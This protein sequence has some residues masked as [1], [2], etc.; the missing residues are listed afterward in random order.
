MVL[1]NQKNNYLYYLFLVGK[2]KKD[3]ARGA[4][5]ASGKKAEGTA[6]GEMPSTADLVWALLSSCFCGFGVL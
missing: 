6:A 3:A 4:E 1:R 5:W 2:K